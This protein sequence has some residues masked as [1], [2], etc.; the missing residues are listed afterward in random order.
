MNALARQM[1]EV[2]APDPT[3]ALT[4]DHVNKAKEIL[5]QRQDTHLDSLAERLREDRVRATIE[6]MLAGQELGNVPN[7]DIQ[8]VL[9]LGLCVMDPLGGITIANSI[10]REVLPRVLTFTELK[11]TPK[12]IAHHGYSWV[13]QDSPIAQVAT[14]FKPI[15]LPSISAIVPSEFC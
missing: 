2:I 3:I 4:R 11:T 5:I 10:Y 9:D 12:G 14:V 8:F 15:E 6:P 1:V 7:D 13:V